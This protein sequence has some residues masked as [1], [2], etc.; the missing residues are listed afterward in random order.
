MANGSSEDLAVSGKGFWKDKKNIFTVILIVIAAAAVVFAV[1]F[2][3]RLTTFLGG[4]QSVPPVGQGATLSLSPTTTNVTANT[5][6]NVDINLNANGALVYATGAYLDFDTSKLAVESVTVPPAS[7]SFDELIE[8]DFSDDLNHPRDLFN[9]TT[10]EISLTLGEYN[11]F[12]VNSLKIATITFRAK[13]SL[14][15]GDVA[16][17]YGGSRGTGP[18]KVNVADDNSLPTDILDQVQNG[19][20]TV[21]PTPP[22]VSTITPNSV[23]EL[24]GSQL[25]VAGA[26][27]D[28]YN[29][30]SAELAL[31]P[32]AGGSA[33]VLTKQSVNNTRIVSSLPDTILPGT[34]DVRVKVAGQTGTLDDGLVVTA[35]PVNP[36]KAPTVN[37]TTQTRWS[38]KLS[39]SWQLAD[40]VDRFDYRVRKDGNIIRD[41]TSNGTNTSVTITNLEN[42]GLTNN[43]QYVIEV[44]GIA[45]SGR[46]DTLIGETGVSAPVRILSANLDHS[47]DEIVGFNDYTTLL[48]DWGRTDRP[49]SDI[50]KDGSVEFWDFTTILIQWN[51]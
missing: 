2:G 45:T 49:E 46:G 39:A 24:S 51:E 19:S 50:N 13:T 37:N 33:T 28:P 11:G 16:F 36:P 8:E 9:N 26:N 5:T 29:N 4:I 1:F 12:V 38:T 40:P 44:R 21:I 18:S 17:G 6:F 23:V 43:S 10:G 48:I 7:T 14:G 15:A 42:P 20:Y 25:T 32:A 31:V 35:E 3:D 34:Y 22:S 47:A 41:W 30:G 27:F